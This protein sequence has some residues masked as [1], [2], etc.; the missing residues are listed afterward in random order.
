[1]HEHLLYLSESEYRS[2]ACPF[3]H[4]TFPLFLC[5]PY[6]PGGE[7]MAQEPKQSPAQPS[8]A[9]GIAQ[10]LSC[11]LWVHIGRTFFTF[12]QK[13]IYFP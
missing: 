13:K 4:F 10:V 6:A 3:H 9:A 12:A 11:C 5:K 1:M 7:A 2:V 8:N